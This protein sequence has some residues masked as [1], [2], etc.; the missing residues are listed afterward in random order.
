[1]NYLKWFLEAKS[2]KMKQIWSEMSVMI[3][4]VHKKKK[5][6]VKGTDLI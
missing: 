3:G 4:A 5:N 6:K 2:V 1:M